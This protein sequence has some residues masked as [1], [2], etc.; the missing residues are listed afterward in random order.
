MVDLANAKSTKI[1]FNYFDWFV[2]VYL[3]P[4]NVPFA[5]ACTLSDVVDC[6]QLHHTLLDEWK[7]HSKN[8]HVVFQKNLHIVFHGSKLIF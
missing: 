2:G 1:N 3:V 4:A 5:A 7:N 8:M 6:M